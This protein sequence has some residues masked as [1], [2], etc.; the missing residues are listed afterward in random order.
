MYT[1]PLPH[2][3]KLKIFYCPSPHDKKVLVATHRY[4]Y[5]FI[6]PESILEIS[7]SCE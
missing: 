3:R 7:C 6:I 5:L 1:Y 2:N 4:E